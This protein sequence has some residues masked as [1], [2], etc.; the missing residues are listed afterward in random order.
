[1]DAIISSAEYQ[2][3]SHRALGWSH[4]EL[5]EQVTQVSIERCYDLKRALVSDKKKP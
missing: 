5:Q 1:M 4:R 3:F 2:I